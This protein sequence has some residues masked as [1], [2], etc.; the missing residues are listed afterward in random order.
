MIVAPA[1][2]ILSALL[3]SPIMFYLGFYI[4]NYCCIVLKV[5]M[6]PKA[7]KRLRFNTDLFHCHPRSYVWGHLSCTMFQI[8]NPNFNFCVGGKI[9][10]GG[11]ADTCYGVYISH[12]LVVYAQ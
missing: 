1:Q 7:T 3:I 12:G 2:C 6:L 10:S 11:I 9:S 4:Q 5:Y 8:R